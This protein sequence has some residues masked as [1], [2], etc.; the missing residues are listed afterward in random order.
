M[1]AISNAIYGLGLNQVRE[2]VMKLVTPSIIVN[3]MHFAVYEVQKQKLE[4]KVQERRV[5]LM[6]SDGNR[7]LK[8]QA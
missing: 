6:E 1:R 7:N 4:S 3:L 8:G 5:R 2:V